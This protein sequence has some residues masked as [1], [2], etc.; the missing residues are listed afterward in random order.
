MR[1]RDVDLKKRVV[2]VTKARLQ[3]GTIVQAG[4]NKHKRRLIPLSEEAVRFLNAATLADENTGYK[5]G[6]VGSMTGIRLYK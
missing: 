6:S 3:D 1:W 4:N 5:P 2:C